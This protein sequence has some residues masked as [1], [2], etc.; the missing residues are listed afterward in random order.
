MFTLQTPDL[1]RQL[2]G[3]LPDLVVNA[4]EGLLGNCA[5]QLEHRAPVTVE[6]DGNYMPNIYGYPRGGPLG[7]NCNGTAVAAI[8]AVNRAGKWVG[9]PCLTDCVERGLAFRGIGPSWFDSARVDTL[10]VG[11]LKDLC[12]NPIEGVSTSGGTEPKRFKITNDSFGSGIALALE[13]EWNGSAYVT[14]GDPFVVADFTPTEEFSSRWRTDYYGWCVQKTDRLGVTVSL[15]DYDLYECLWVESKARWIEFELTS[16]VTGGTASADVLYAWGADDRADVP[17][18]VTIY[19]RTGRFSEA[20]TGDKGIAVWDE[21]ERKYIPLHSSGMTGVVIPSDPDVF[22]IKITNGEQNASCLFEGIAVE[23]NM[24]SPNFCTQD[25]WVNGDS[26]WV[27]APNRDDNEFL[28]V[29]SIH[30]GILLDESYDVGG[31]VRPLYMIKDDYEQFELLKFKESARRDDCTYSAKIVEVLTDYCAAENDEEGEDVYVY[32]PN[33]TDL[34]DMI[35][36]PTYAWGKLIKIEYNGRK[37][38]LSKLDIRNTRCLFAIVTLDPLDCADSSGTARIEE[39]VKQGEHVENWAEIGEEVEF[40]NTFSFCSESGKK[41]LLLLN[42]G[43]GEK[44]ILIQVQ[45]VCIELVT[46]VQAEPPCGL[47][48]T[49]VTASVIFCSESSQS[50][51]MEDVICD[52]CSE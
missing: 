31:D 38:F 50:L 44:P 9:D 32:L 27:F 46:D 25:F 26:C 41:G 43:E 14:T 22:C 29:G 36:G 7:K 23:A 13:V 6:I 20:V 52:C 12:G 15:N 33:S 51:P 16:D 11:S 30:L 45:H 37:L 40:D 17:S 24:T 1:V 42:D 18:T 49:K 47:R 34:N 4:F 19:D 10:Y 8:T 35:T 48:V 28:N 21:Q 3:Q 39:F 2:R 5:Q